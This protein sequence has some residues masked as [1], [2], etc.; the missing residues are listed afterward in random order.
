MLFRNTCEF[1]KTLKKTNEKHKI[2]DSGYFW[3]KVMCLL[4][5]YIHVCIYQHAHK[6]IY[7]S[8]HLS[9]IYAFF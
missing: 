4:C 7:E 8:T 2:Q 9:I 6:D 3:R 1:L 5:V